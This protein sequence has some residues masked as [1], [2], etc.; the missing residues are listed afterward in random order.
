MSDD[1]LCEIRLVDYFKNQDINN[2][3][4]MKLLIG[5]DNETAPQEYSLADIYTPDPIDNTDAQVTEV[6]GTVFNDSI[7]LS[8]DVAETVWGGN[9][10][11]TIIASGGSD[12]IVGGRGNDVINLNN[13]GSNLVVIDEENVGFV[14]TV[15]NYTS[16]DAISFFTSCNADFYKLS[17]LSCYKSSDDLVIT[18]SDGGQVV[19]KDYFTSASKIDKILFWDEE[20]E[21]EVEFSIRNNLITEISD[22]TEFIGTD[23]DEEVRLV[24]GTVNQEEDV[25][26]GNTYISN[27]NGTEYTVDAFALGMGGNDVIWGTDG[28]D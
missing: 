8:A 3:T 27:T 23:S 21:Q 16:T 10:N 22:V 9:G 5:G 26:H 11:D 28:N 7:T 17:D 4:F 6:F 25:L 24:K 13:S 14:E 15:E 20:H 12:S 1:G 2:P 18:T 19:I